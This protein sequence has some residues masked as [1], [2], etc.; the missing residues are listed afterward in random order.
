MELTNENRFAA[1]ALLVMIFRHRRLLSATTRLELLKRYSGSVLGPA[2]VVLYPLLFLCVYLFL[3]LVVFKMR[4]PGFSELDY[5]VFVFSGLVPFLAVIE[6]AT[7]A[8]ASIKQNM[9]LIRNVIMPIDLIPV[10][11]V[12][13][14]LASEVVGLALLLVLLALDRD[15]SWKILALPLVLVVQA[16]FLIGLALILAALGVL[17]PDINPVVG[18]TFMLLLFISPIAF[19]P[20]MV[21]AGLD[22]VLALNPTTYMLEAFR[23]CLLA[24]HPLRVDRVLIFVMLSALLFVAGATFFRKFKGHI[25]DYE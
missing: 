22:L 3:Y 18:L 16:A 14:A 21:P 13:L 2:W 7:T 4:F 10:R 6:S 25:V 11:T 19:K 5:V 23:A 1:T 9:H 8:T 20:D 15:L 24:D 17:F 12:G